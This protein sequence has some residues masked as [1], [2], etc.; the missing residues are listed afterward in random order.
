[1]NHEEHGGH[2]GPGRGMRLRTPLPEETERTIT[3]IIGCAIEVHRAL[4]PGYLESI[5]KRAM[6]IEMASRGLSFEAERP[7]YVLYRGVRIPGQRVDLIVGDQV[8]VEMKAIVRV[9]DVHRAQVMSYMKT[10]GL[11]AGLLINFRV[12]VLKQGLQRFVL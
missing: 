4:G 5:Y 11:R 8:I 1:M 12:P 3:A 6:I 2:E 9:D 10:T 7:V